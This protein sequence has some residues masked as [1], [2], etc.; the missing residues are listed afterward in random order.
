MT[1]IKTIFQNRTYIKRIYFLLLLLVFIGCG[2]SKENKEGLTIATAANMQFA[3]KDLMAAFTSK[4]GTPCHMVTGSSGKLMAQIKE[5]APYHVFV[6]ADIKYAN[7]LYAN[8]LAENT[9]KIYAHGKLVLWSMVDDLEPSIEL[10]SS[11][12]VEYIAMANPVIAPYGKATKEVL[13]HYQLTK[14]VADKLVYG[15]S[16]SQTN[17][18]IISEAATI[19]FTSLSVVLSPH[20]KDK[21]KWVL[22][23]ETTYNPIEQAIVIIKGD[24]INNNADKFYAFLF[25][26]EGKRILERYGYSINHDSV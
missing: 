24:N 23:D 16:I 18:F 12:K 11:S 17:Q 13:Q 25:S 1:T 9:P 14:Q 10:L 2:N 15:E 8:G 6:S 7:E 22:I 26:D 4:T 5:G 19:G 20:M 21:G 3:M